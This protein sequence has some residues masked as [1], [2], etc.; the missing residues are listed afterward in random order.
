MQLQELLVVQGR[1]LQ[2]QLLT[3]RARDRSVQERVQEPAQEREPAP[4][5]ERVQEPGPARAPVRQFQSSVWAR[6][7]EQVPVRVLSTARGQALDLEADQGQVPVW[8]RQL[9]EDPSAFQ[10][11]ALVPAQGQ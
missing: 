11:E 10:A 3:A 8:E 1:H 2:K 4:E 7:P 9:Q 5:R 6:V